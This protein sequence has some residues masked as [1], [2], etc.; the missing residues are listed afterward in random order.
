MSFLTASGELQVNNGFRDLHYFF[1]SRNPFYAVKEGTVTIVS[2]STNHNA[3]YGA[4]PLNS[5]TTTTK[6]SGLFFARVSYKNAHDNLNQV[7]FNGNS[8]DIGAEVADNILKVITDSTGKSLLADAEDIYWN[9]EWFSKASTP[10][11]HGLL[12]KNFHTFYFEEK[13]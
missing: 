3:F 1:A 10:K 6:Q 12:Q 11:R 13:K 4:S 7:N 5:T 8:E 9:E 2:E